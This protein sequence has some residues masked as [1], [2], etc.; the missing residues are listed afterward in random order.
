VTVIDGKTN[1]AATIPVG[2]TP[3]ALAVDQVRDNIYVVNN[4]NITVIDGKT[5]GTT[6][7]GSNGSGP[8]DAAVDVLTNGLYA[9]NNAGASISV[10]AGANAA[11]PIPLL[12]ELLGSANGVR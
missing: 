11:F 10:F 2:S 4:G 8:L 12:D 1:T 7:V 9:M 3:I 6:T 5:N